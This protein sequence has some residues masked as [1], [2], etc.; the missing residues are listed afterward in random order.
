MA[1]AGDKCFSS[2]RALDAKI[3]Q[4]EK[5]IPKSFDDPPSVIG[6]VGPAAGDNVGPVTQEVGLERYMPSPKE[7][8][9]NAG[10]PFDYY[11]PVTS[12]AG[13]EYTLSPRKLRENAGSPSDYYYPITQEK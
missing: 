3:E 4:T 12:E 2:V 11:N 7:I 10:N 5:S 6:P 13:P 8:G 9:E 1:S